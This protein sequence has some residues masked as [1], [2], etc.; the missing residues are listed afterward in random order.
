MKDIHVFIVD[1]SSERDAYAYV[2]NAGAHLHYG[3]I[4]LHNMRNHIMRYFPVGTEMVCMDDDIEDLMYMKE[5]VSIENVK[6]AKRYPLHS[7][8]ANYFFT[9]MANTFEWMKANHIHM[10][11]IYAVKNGYFMK[12]LPPITTDLR[13]C[14][15]TFWG[16]INRHDISIT[17]EEKEDVERTLKCFLR[18]QSIL[19]FN[20]IAPVTKYYKT[21]GGMQ[22]HGV[23]RKVAAQESAHKIVATYPQLCTLYTAKKSGVCEVKFKTH[24]TA[25]CQNHKIADLSWLPEEDHT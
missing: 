23:D 16:C 10:F 4:G 12:S 5:D 17:M 19:R 20:H 24:S 14:V 18:D 1:E 22:A 11:G 13:F 15:G 21:K 6:S 2:Q 8:P 7:Y 3:P 25:S 9:W